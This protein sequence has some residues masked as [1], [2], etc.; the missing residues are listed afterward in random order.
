MGGFFYQ[1]WFPRRLFIGRKSVDRSRDSVL[2]SLVS[3][4]SSE[5]LLQSL[6]MNFLEPVVVR[7]A[8]FCL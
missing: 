3:L 2:D 4:Y 8:L 5:F 1:R 6:W 7:A